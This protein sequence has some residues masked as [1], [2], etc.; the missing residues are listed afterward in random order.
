MLIGCLR[1]DGVADARLQVRVS[2]HVQVRTGRGA[3]RAGLELVGLDRAAGRGTRGLA[4]GVDPVLNCSVDPTNCY[5]AGVVKTTDCGRSWAAQFKN[6]DTGDNF[7]PNGIDCATA[8]HCVAVFE[9]DTCRVLVT[10]DGGKE[11]Q[12]TMR[13][14]DP[15]CSLVSVRM[16]SETEGWITGTHLSAADF[17]GR[18]WHTADGGKTWA[19]E[20]IPNLSIQGLWM[21]GGFGYAVAI[22]KADGVKLLR[23]RAAPAEGR[24]KA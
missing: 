10:T 24:Y 2:E 20:A 22:T 15:A 13:D 11:W 3:G 6:V 19:K 8:D 1:S 9:G 5:A 7:Y 18:F 12:E 14:T 4:A 23:Y 17:E 16:L 21:E